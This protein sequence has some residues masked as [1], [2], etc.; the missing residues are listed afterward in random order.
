[1]ET[2][3]KIRNEPVDFAP[4]G[5]GSQS[6]STELVDLLTGL[7]EKDPR[8]RLTLE[9]ALAHPWTAGHGSRRRSGGQ[10]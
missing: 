1:M 10:R 8:R 9:E 2:Y 6:V 5:S 4:N 7:L 3:S